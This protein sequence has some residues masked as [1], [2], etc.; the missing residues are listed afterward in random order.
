M[1]FCRNFMPETNCF[2]TISLC[3]RTWASEHHSACLPCWGVC[4]S[5]SPLLVGKES[6]F[7]CFPV[8][9]SSIWN[10]AVPHGKWSHCCITAFVSV[11]VWLSACRNSSMWCNWRA[12]LLPHQVSSGFTWSLGVNSCT[13]GKNAK[14]TMGQKCSDAVLD[15]VM[16]LK[17]CTHC[18][19][20]P[21]QPFLADSLLLS[22]ILMSNL[23]SLQ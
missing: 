11:K 23:G 6:S 7:C 1:L 14:L 8:K 20:A 19:F 16:L 21:F 4:T 2:K 3:S 10:G 13:K 5:S 12:D 22:L 15:L 9:L 17:I 18:D